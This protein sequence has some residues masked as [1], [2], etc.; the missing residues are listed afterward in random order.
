[1][2]EFIIPPSSVL[3]SIGDTPHAERADYEVD[4]EDRNF[5]RRFILH[6]IPA[7]NHFNGDMFTVE[8][9]PPPPSRMEII[10]P[11]ERFSQERQTGDTVAQ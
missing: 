8:R 9:Y 10:T 2:K 1:M 11:V 4:I 6:F 7:G 5:M 3:I